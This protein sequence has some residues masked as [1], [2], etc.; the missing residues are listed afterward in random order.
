MRYFKP[1]E[2]QHCKPSCTVA[3]MNPSFLDKLDAVRDASGTSMRLLSAFRSSSYDRAHGRTGKGFHT[4][5]RAVDVYCADGSSRAKIIRACLALSLT[6]GVYSTFLHID[7][8][9]NC[10]VFYG[11]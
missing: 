3:D 7:D 4:Y 5:G 2:F 11:K 9:P 8:R 6:V 10:I 1:E